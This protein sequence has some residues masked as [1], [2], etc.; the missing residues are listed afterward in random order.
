[1]WAVS[2]HGASKPTPVRLLG[3]GSGRLISGFGQDDAGELYLCDLNG[4]V[5]RIVG[6]LG[7]APAVISRSSAEQAVHLSRRVVVG[8]A[9][10]EHALRRQAQPLDD[11]RRV[12]VAP[13]GGD[14]PVPQG[15]GD[16]LAVNARGT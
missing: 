16:G 15:R 6:Q 4:S 12:E 8:Q 1:M 5:Y 13:P 14:P 10:P 7:Q 2:Q 3:T 11:A 9:D